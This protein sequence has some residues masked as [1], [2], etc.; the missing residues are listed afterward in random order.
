MIIEIMDDDKVFFTAG[1]V[2]TL[3]QDI[4]NKPIM[5]VRSIDK[6]SAHAERPIL[7]GITCLWFTTTG[8]A[9]EKRFNTKDLSKVD[10]KK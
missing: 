6:V 7:F 10:T 4:P 1:E 3:R 2:V 9:Q 5:I 8:E